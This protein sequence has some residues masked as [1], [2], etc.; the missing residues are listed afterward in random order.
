MND[1]LIHLDA[2]DMPWSCAPTKGVSF[3]T[4]RFDHT[5]RAGAVMIHMCPDTTYPR[6]TTEK[7]QDVYVIDGELIIDGQHVRRGAYTWMPAGEEH[8]PHSEKG[9]VLFVA[10]PGAVHHHH[11]ELSFGL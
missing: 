10:F 9:C 6:F 5:T 7:G 3:K 11:A 1:K 8:A 4:L 2:E